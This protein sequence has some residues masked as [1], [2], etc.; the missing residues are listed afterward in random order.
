[1]D[2]AS[3]ASSAGPSRGSS[4]AGRCR[5]RRK[6]GSLFNDPG[7]GATNIEKSQ[8]AGVKFGLELY[9]VD[10]PADQTRISLDLG[11]HVVA[12]FEGREYSEMW[13][14]FALAGDRALQGPLILDADPTRAASRRSATPA[15]RT[16]RTTSRPTGRFALRAQIGP[17]VRFAVLG[18]LIWKTDHVIYVRRC[19]RRSRTTTTTWLTRAP[20]EVNPLHVPAIDLVGHRYRSEDGFG[21]VIGS[22]AQVL[23]L[24]ASISASRSSPRQG[25]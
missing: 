23:V 18:D 6:S 9:A 7:F 20:N 16:S 14:L 24:A 8:Q 21:F 10:N 22:P 5:S 25:R 11:S 17:H 19:R 2:D 13:E 15:S 3:R 1:M 12:H 4:C